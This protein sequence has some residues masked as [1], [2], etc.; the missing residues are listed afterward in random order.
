MSE[1]ARCLTICGVRPLSLTLYRRFYPWHSREF[2]GTKLSNTGRKERKS[3]RGT[4]KK[5]YERFSERGRDVQAARKTD[6]PRRFVTTSGN[7]SKRPFSIL[8]TIIAGRS[9][10]IELLY[11]RR[12]KTRMEHAR[13]YASYVIIGEKGTGPGQN[14]RI[15]VSFGRGVC[16]RV[17]LKE[18]NTEKN[19]LSKRA[20]Q[21]SKEAVVPAL[22]DVG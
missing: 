14:N 15:E 20:A 22:I 18:E 12:R 16:K 9:V 13:R 6:S 3:R 11:A 7:R 2:R 10:G 21:F 19:E 17:F 4:K 8:L 1:I 5:I